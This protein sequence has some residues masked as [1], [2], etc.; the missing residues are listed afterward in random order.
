MITADTVGS[1]TIYPLLIFRFIN[2]IYN[3][4]FVIIQLHKKYA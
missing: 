3:L 2:K 4:L 1:K